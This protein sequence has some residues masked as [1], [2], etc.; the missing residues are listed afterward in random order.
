[1][2]DL[3]QGHFDKLNGT[4]G[5]LRNLLDSIPANYDHER[6]ADAVHNRMAAAIAQA[7]DHTPILEEI[8]GL[9]LNDHESRMLQ[10]IDAMQETLLTSILEAIGSINMSVVVNAKEFTNGDAAERLSAAK[11]PKPSSSVARASSAPRLE[12]ARTQQRPSYGNSS[13]SNPS[14][15]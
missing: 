4:H 13:F 2:S 3:M 11:A 7:T 6:T 1:M 10:V 14:P 9:G 12:S 8:R 5:E 15:A